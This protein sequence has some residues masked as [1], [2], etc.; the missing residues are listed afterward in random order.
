MKKNTYGTVSLN[1]E[2]LEQLR[3]IADKERRSMA[4]QIDHW[5]EQYWTG[6]LQKESA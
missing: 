4:G 2:V 3:E 6:K 1:H 5:I